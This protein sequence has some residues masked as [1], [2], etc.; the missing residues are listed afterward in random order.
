MR[1]QAIGRAVLAMDDLLQRSDFGDVLTRLRTAY[2]DAGQAW[3]LDQGDAATRQVR[4]GLAALTE[5]EGTPLLARTPSEHPG[6]IRLGLLTALMT[7]CAGKAD[8][9]VHA[10]DPWHPQPVTAAAWKP[11]LVVCS[12]CPHLTSLPRGSVRDRTC[13]GCGTVTLFAPGEQRGIWPVTVSQGSF[14]Y[15][16]GV[17]VDCRYWPTGE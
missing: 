3:F 2:Q 17:C 1:D 12:R 13:D 14:M 4:T 9:C 5:A 15:M 8:T 6:W 10:P 16:A 11:G 7:W